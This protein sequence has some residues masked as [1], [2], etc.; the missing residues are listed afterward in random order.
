MIVRRRFARV[1]APA[2]LAVFC[3]ILLGP[4]PAAATVVLEQPPTIGD[5]GG[6]GLVS[7]GSTQHFDDFSLAGDTTITGVGWHGSLG[8]QAG[9]GDFVIRFFQDDGAGHPEA[10]PFFSEMVTATGTQTKMFEFEFFAALT[11]P[12]I[13]PGGTDLWISILIDDGSNFTWGR[14]AGAPSPGSMPAG[15]AFSRFGDGRTIYQGQD[16]AFSLI[17]GPISVPE[18]GTLALL[19][20]GLAGVGLLRRRKRA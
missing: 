6:A 19:V 11:N 17:S 1:V 8:M 20:G 18:P 10:S 13:L 4:R 9:P 12:V 5:L 16:L 3:A 14:A 15:I 2:L 7:N